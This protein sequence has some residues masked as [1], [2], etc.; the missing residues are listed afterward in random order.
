MA[1]SQSTSP[2][3]RNKNK[4]SYKYAVPTHLDD[5]DNMKAEDYLAIKKKEEMI[6]RL[7]RKNAEEFERLQL[8]QA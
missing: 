7:E 5:K 1:T 6:E 4:A 3:N 8:M 2:L